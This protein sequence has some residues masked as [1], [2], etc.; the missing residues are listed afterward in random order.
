MNVCELA[1]SAFSV[2]YILG[3]SI[4]RLIVSETE[5][6]QNFKVFPQSA[7]GILTTALKV[8]SVSCTRQA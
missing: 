1:H 2:L 6:L 3:F 8:L 5:I 4:F 7:D